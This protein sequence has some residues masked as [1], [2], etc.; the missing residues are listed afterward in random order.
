MKSPSFAIPALLS[1][2][3]V[4]L[5][6]GCQVQQPW[7]LTAHKE[8]ETVQLCL[9]HET[10]CPQPGGIQLDSISVYRYDDTF[11]NE[12]VWDASSETETTDPID[13]IIT[14]GIAPKN[15]RSKTN[16]PPPACG[17]AYLVNPGAIYFGLKCD[18]TIVV[19]QDPHLE[20]FFRPEA[21]PVP[22]KKR[23]G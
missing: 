15:W 1:F 5:W 4:S 14:Y 20:E 17:K 3:L 11:H 21:P 12:L 8:G 18:G 10:A 23:G 2:C 9:S 6:T 13:G 16:P 22:A 7:H 19:F